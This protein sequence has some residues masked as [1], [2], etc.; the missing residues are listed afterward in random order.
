MMITVH[1]LTNGAEFYINPRHITHVFPI[2][3]GDGEVHSCVYMAHGTQSFFEV[4]ETAA[5][6]LDRIKEIEIYTTRYIQGIQ[7]DKINASLVEI[8]SQ[9]KNM[10][11][12]SK[13]LVELRLQLRNTQRTK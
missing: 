4:E 9:L 5:I 11:K 3:D 7:M 12:I 2:K 6:V 10:E 13:E 1:L 8:R